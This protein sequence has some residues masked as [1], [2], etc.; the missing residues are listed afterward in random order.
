MKKMMINHYL[1]AL[2]MAF[3]VLLTTHPANALQA[4]ASLNMSAPTFTITDLD[5]TD[6]ITPQITL[7]NKNS[8][9]GWSWS[10]QPN[11]GD[12]FT[13]LVDYSNTPLAGWTNDLSV[14]HTAPGATSNTVL[15]SN[16]LST[17]NVTGFDNGYALWSQCSFSADFT[18]TSN[19]QLDIWIPANLMVDPAGADTI[20]RTGAEAYARTTLQLSSLS[21]QVLA[22]DTLW[23]DHWT[24][25][26]L[27][28]GLLH[29]S[30]QNNTGSDYTGSMDVSAYSVTMSYGSS[31]TVPEPTTMFLLVIG[32][33]G[34]AGAKRKFQK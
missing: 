29:V 14:S 9:A 6:G 1:V 33:V 20:P 4:S 16:S 28:N 26:N 8:Y 17:T 32:I 5:S 2:A 24:S 19:T 10:R 30:F 7:S 21:Y 12:Y 31:T 27:N 11:P 22:Y 23:L 25:G 34:L 18:L 3:L 13:Q 15:T